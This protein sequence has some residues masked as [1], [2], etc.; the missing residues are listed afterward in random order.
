MS[1]IASECLRTQRR[2]QA[3]CSTGHSGSFSYCLSFFSRRW[4][5][6]CLHK[7]FRSTARL[8]KSA[9]ISQIVD[10]SPLPVSFV[11]DL[12]QPTSPRLTPIEG[13]GTFGRVRLVRHLDNGKFYALKISKKASII[14]MKQVWPVVLLPGSRSYV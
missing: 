14:R 7:A 11:S 13:T 10:G 3:C 6:T 5:R 8:Y 4:V 12:A 1:G 2:V 9:G